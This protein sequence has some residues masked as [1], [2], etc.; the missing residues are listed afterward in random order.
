M[1]KNKWYRVIGSLLL[2]GGIFLVARA[3]VAQGHPPGSIPW[4]KLGPVGLMGIIGGI[5][6]LFLPNNLK[7]K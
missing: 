5:G 7:L 1:T 4:L 2:V 3:F 6:L